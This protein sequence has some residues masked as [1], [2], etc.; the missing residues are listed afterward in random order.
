MRRI[1]R[2][3]MEPLHGRACLPSEVVQARFVHEHDV[4]SGDH[5]AEAQAQLAEVPRTDR[6]YCEGIVQAFQSEHTF[7]TVLRGRVTG[8][9]YVRPVD[10]SSVTLEHL[11]VAK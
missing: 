8:V 7:V 6:V 1:G 10:S 2:S 9:Y 3:A 4:G 5:I 11:F